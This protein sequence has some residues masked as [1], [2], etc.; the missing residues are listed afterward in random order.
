MAYVKQVWENLPSTDTPVSAERLNYMESGIAEAWEHGGG[1]GDTLPIGIIL[2]LSSDTIP[3]GYLLCDGS[4]ISRTEYSTLF[5]AIGTTYGA[6]D[7]S[8]T[9]NLPNL[10]GK[11]PVGQD[12]NDNNFDTLGET[13]GE[14]THTLTTNEIPSHTH[15]IVTKGNTGFASGYVFSEGGGYNS[16]FSEAVGGGQAHNNLQPYIVINYIIKVSQTTST[17]A[18]I[19]DGY[20]T[21]TTDGY[22]ANYINNIFESKSFILWTNSSPASDFSPQ[23]ITLSSD[24]Y[25]IL[26]FFWRSDVGGNRI[27]ST[28]TLK[29]SSVQSDM[30][31][32]VVPTRAWRRRADYVSDTSYSVG[33]CSRMEYNQTAYNENGYCVPLYVI[34]YKTGLFS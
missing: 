18:Q 31:S 11:V 14:K 24:D 32:T 20:S 30:Y 3:E 22:S 13:G 25:D 7:G 34:G 33:N 21:S 26:E 1:G 8:T 12:T 16:A 29:G 9:F 5:S 19:V 2:P 23:N 6:G 28:K 27:F 10:K 17:Q 4:A 15:G